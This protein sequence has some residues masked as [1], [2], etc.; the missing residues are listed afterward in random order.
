MQ[1]GVIGLGRMGGNIVRR[2]M[3]NGHRCVVFD[4]DAKAVGGLAQDGATGVKS[5]EE[6]VQ[7]L[8]AQSRT[9]EAART[10]LAACMKKGSMAWS[11]TS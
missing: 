1:L 11:S 10:P 2:L 6:M 7:A 3:K 9:A 4:R 5:L 8:K